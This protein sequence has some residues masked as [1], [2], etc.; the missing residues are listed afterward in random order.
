MLIGL[1]AA[2]RRQAII[3]SFWS[4]VAWAIL[5]GSWF[6][7]KDGDPAFSWVVTA[8]ISLGISVLVVLTLPLGKVADRLA[9]HLRPEPPTQQFD[10]LVT[11]IA[12]ALV[13]PV[14]SI[15]TYKCPVPNV[16]ML[17]C[18]N[19]E[20]VVATTGALEELSRYEL[21]ALVA[22][23]FAGMRSRWCRMAT[24]AEIMWWA[25]PWFFPIGL[26]GLLVGR[27]IATF[28]AFGFIF[29]WAFMPRKT[30]Q[31][32]D[33]CADIAAVRTTLDPNSLA[34]AMRK[35][36]A[37][38]HA[39]T[40]INFGKWYLPM[41]PFLVIPKR[42]ESKTTVNGRTWNQADEVR[43]EFMLRADRAEAMVNGANPSEFTGREFSKRWKE[44]GK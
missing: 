29:V 31:A 24:R 39:A 33:L 40:K 20:I 35:L 26:A 16:F 32:R 30:E 8:A 22:A 1:E 28:V 37:H 6:V 2:A 41:N 4:V 17:P 21:Q 44:L 9:K 3:A 36:A 42:G 34:S 23:Q 18:S 15:Q 19:R 5:I 7:N 38:A 14:E 12:I 27:P 10:N 11:E 13:E 43:L 25:L